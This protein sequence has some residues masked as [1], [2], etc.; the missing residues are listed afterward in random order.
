M[1]NNDT[2]NKIEDIISG[3]HINWQANHCTTARNYLCRSFSPSTTVKENFE[4][5]ARVKKEQAE[6]LI[7]FIE[8]HHLWIDKPPPEER[9]LTIGGEAEVFINAKEGY[10]TKINDAI[11]YATWL[12]FLTS[13]LI[14]NLL[15]GET[16]YEL[17]GFSKRDGNLTAILKQSFIVSDAPIDM[18]EV[19]EVLEFVGFANVRRN[20][21]YNKQLGLILEDIHDE[22]VIMNSNFIFFIDTVFYIDLSRK[23]V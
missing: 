9:F 10:V 19:K 2:R 16:A 22:N 12:D 5:K 23:S 11:Y 7:K 3:T 13:I 14:H 17:I 1:I 15:F 21:Y 8:Q 4:G 20:D 6:L 18:N